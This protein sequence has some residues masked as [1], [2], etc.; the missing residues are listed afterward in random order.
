M[1]E[2]LNELVIIWDQTDLLLVPTGEWTMHRAGEKVIPI[3]NSDD[4][5]QITAVLAASMTGDCLAPQL[6]FGGKTERCHP[7]VSF[8]E[9][10]DIWHSDIH[11][12]NEDTMQ[13]YIE[14]I[15][16]P[17]ITWK[18]EALRLEKYHPALTVFKARRLLALSHY[19]RRTTSSL[20]GF[21]Q[22]ALISYSRWTSLR[23][24]R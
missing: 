1:N 21:H 11:W 2:I 16:I 5:R 3:A 15:I 24:N 23:T 9:G 17:F 6:I 12:S 7:R 13:H 18:R 20:C 19:L 10:W 8:P 22:I 4:K 14:R